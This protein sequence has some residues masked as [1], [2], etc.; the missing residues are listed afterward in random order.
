MKPG[1]RIVLVQ[2]QIPP[3]TGN[4]ARLCAAL[5]VPLFLVGELGFEITDRYLKRAGL[6]YWH[7]VDVN[8]CPDVES[9]FEGLAAEDV[10]LLTKRATA[11]YAEVRYEAGD[12]L[13]FGSETKGLPDWVL[14]AYPDRHRRIPM[15]SQG[16]RSLN[17]SSAAAIVA[18]EA[19]RQTD[20]FSGA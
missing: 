9:F 20:L 11:S 1:P 13:V 10:H 17:L 6:D 3:N 4:V 19:A 18:Y 2:P 15:R 12:Y 7:L 16:V 8:V 14:A 5:Q